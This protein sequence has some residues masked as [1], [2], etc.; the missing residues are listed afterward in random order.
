MTKLSYKVLDKIISN[1]LTSHEINLIIC[2]SRFQKDTGEIIGVSYKK[3]CEETGMSIQKF[4]DALHSLCDKNI[5]VYEKR[6]YWDIDITILDNDFS[7]NNYSDGYI[8]TN[9]H[10]FYMDEFKE[11]KAG[12][13]ILA[14][15]LM[16]VTFTC[17]NSF[18]VGIKKFRDKYAGL[19][20][21]SK[22]TLLL[23]LNKLKRFFSIGIKDKKYF[24]TPK[25]IIY[26]DTRKKT[27]SELLN[28]QQIMVAIK[29]NRI[30]DATE[31]DI[32]DTLNVLNQYNPYLKENKNF[33]IINTINL[34][35]QKLNDKILDKRKWKR[36]LYPKFIHILI[37]GELGLT[38]KVIVS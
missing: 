1:K 24:I 27:E 31:Q 8:N 30:K 29:R 18:Q 32:K 12:A 4:Y 13:K 20:Q 9:H 35:I 37:Q 15:L 19:M 23:Y 10:I 11:L 3:V 22:R 2:I 14:M 26:N 6:S 28:N 7:D 34:S 21:I 33:S 25:S 16:K 38:N 17:R 36:K 5:I